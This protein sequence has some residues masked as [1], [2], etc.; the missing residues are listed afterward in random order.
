VVEVLRHARAAHRTT[1][2][3]VGGLVALLSAC[4]VYDNQALGSKPA[5]PDGGPNYPTPD[6]GTPTGI[7]GTGG[8]DAAGAAGN[9]EPDAGTPVPA[10]CESLQGCSPTCPERCNKKDDDCD[11]VVDEVA[12]NAMCKA[13]HS[14]SLCERGSCLLVQ[15]LDQYRDC[16]D[17]PA[18]GCEVAIDDPK[19]CGKCGSVCDLPNAIES[20]SDGKCVAIGCEDG[21][22][23]CDGDQVSCELH[24]VGLDHCAGCS[25]VCG[26]LTNASPQCDTG[27]CQVKDCRGNFGDCDKDSKNGCETALDS[28]ANCGGCNLPCN[29]ASCAG[30]VCSAVI[31]TAPTAD[32]DRDEVNCEV[33]LSSDVNHCGGCGLVCAFKTATPHATLSCIDRN[34]D[35]ACDATFGDCDEDYASGCETPLNTTASHCGACGKN[36]TAMLPHTATTSCSAAT[37]AVVTCASGWGNCDN[38]ASNGCE[39]NT[40]VEGPC[41]PDGNCIKQTYATHD[42]YFCSNAS[43]WSAARARCQMQTRGDLVAISSSGE[44]AFLQSLRTANAWIGARDTAIEGLWRWERN[45]V[46]FWRGTGGGTVQ[47]AQYTRWASS[48]P[49][50]AS[51]AEDCAEMLSDGTWDDADCAGA[52]AFICEVMPDECPS[53]ANKVDPGQCGCGNADTDSDSDGFADCNETCDTDPNKQSPG[54]CGCGASDADN[55]ADGSANCLDGCPSDPTQTSAC[56]TFA[57]TNF[58]PNPINWSAQPATTL[59]CGTTTVNTDDPDGTGPLV[60]TI[61]NW[62]G[63]VPVPIVQ[64][65]TGGPQVVVV[66]LRSL[67]LSSGATLRLL[68]SRPVILAIDGAATIDGV[69]DASASGTSAGA[70]GNWSCGTSQ[71]GNGSG[72]TVRRD[73]ASGGGGGGYGTAGGKAGTADTDGSDVPGGNAGVTRGAATLSPLIAGCAGGLA[74][75]CSTVGGAGGGGV[76]ISAS[77]LLDVNGTIRANG[78]AGALPCGSGDEGGGTGGGSGG[79]ILLEATS[80]DTAGSTLQVDGG[81][82]GANGDYAG[83]Y[84]CGG[85]SGG[86]GSTSSGSTGGGGTSCQGGSSGGGGGYGRI[87][88]GTR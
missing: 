6:T 51:A 21:Y 40:A 34:C 75:G 72:S 14:T 53:D 15:C 12:A 86:A 67:I 9:A 49:D 23:D 46:T 76:Q 25:T 54:T 81:S 79:A 87:K 65:Q 84:N 32:C 78:G 29:K 2:A 60:A 36:C 16:D 58:D 31:C 24:L 66:P 61:T 13:P 43:A 26:G 35:A 30:G 85:S 4:S 59:N 27:S 80:I 28:L 88:T 41:N 20:C 8:D 68:G 83:I 7:A 3:T 71:G 38:L 45:G 55:D 19:H 50:A 11:G 48:Q 82:G 52:H 70:G 1:F 10:E 39:R 56:L 42:Y 73:G 37:C 17:D 77:G 22:G 69:I 18:N 5:S 57:P 64:N 74:G 63:T 44:D 47:L 33:D 62:C